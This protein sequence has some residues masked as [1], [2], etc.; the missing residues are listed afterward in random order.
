[1]SEY[2]E[3]KKGDQVKFTWGL[4]KRIFKIALKPKKKHGIFYLTLE[5]DKGVRQDCLAQWCVHV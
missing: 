3:F 4:D 2:V 5:D 1:M